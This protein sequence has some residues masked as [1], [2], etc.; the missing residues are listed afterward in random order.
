M[1]YIQKHGFKENAFK[2][3]LVQCAR[4]NNGIINCKP[5]NSWNES[6]DSWLH[7][8]STDLAMLKITGF[9]LT[10]RRKGR[11]IM[12]WSFMK[13]KAFHPLFK[14]FFKVKNFN[15]WKLD[16]NFCY[17]IFTLDISNK[18]NLFFFSF[19]IFVE[20]LY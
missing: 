20:K 14:I 8:Q 15:K 12:W 5:P 18:T 7:K 9:S 11:R 6:S 13:I 17:R 10:L 1:G 19:R 4:L 16:Y 3:L 2:G